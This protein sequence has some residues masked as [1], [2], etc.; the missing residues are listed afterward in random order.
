IV[1]ASVAEDSSRQF[2]KALKKRSEEYTKGRWDLLARF[3]GDL[4]TLEEE[5]RQ[6]RSFADESEKL[7]E[8][9]RK[10]LAELESITESSSELEED[11]AKLGET[12]R[13]VEHI[14]LEFIRQQ[15]VFNKLTAGSNGGNSLV[16]NQPFSLLPELNSLSCMQLLKLGTGLFM[17]VVIGIIAAAGIIAAVILMTMGG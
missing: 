1:E 4:A 10:L 17:P 7:Q 14:R 12:W 8:T 11:S 13:K 6:Y 16:G 3:T 5:A 9:I 15:A 2:K